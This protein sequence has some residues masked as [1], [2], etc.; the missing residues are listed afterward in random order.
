L[1]IAGT[2]VEVFGLVKLEE[3]LLRPLDSSMPVRQD[4][5]NPST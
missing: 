4:F 2:S 3:V 5:F 1:E